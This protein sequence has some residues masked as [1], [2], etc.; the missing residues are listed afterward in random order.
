MK[1]DSVRMAV[2]VLVVPVVVLLVAALL[3]GV[4]WAEEISD[5]KQ[6]A[7][8]GDAAAQC[9]LGVRYLTGEGV[10]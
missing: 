8:S 1:K 10:E 5:L 6:K 3:A 4:T 7:E 9:E 2:S